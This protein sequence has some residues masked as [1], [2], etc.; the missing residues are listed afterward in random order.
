MVPLTVAVDTVAGSGATDV[1]RA[2]TRRSRETGIDAIRCLAFPAVVLIHL[3]SYHVPVETQITAPA[4]LDQLC[5]FAVPYYFVASGYFLGETERP[6]LVA[7]RRVMMRLSLVFVFWEA[8]YLVASGTSVAALSDPSLLR[9]IILRG[10]PGYHLW[11]LP[12]LGVCV[13]LAIALRRLP[14]AFRLTIGL[15]CF[16]VGIAF[17]PYRESLGLPSIGDTRTG[18]WFG[19]VFVMSGTVLRSLRI[20]HLFPLGV[21]LIAIGIASQI[22]EAAFLAMNGQGGF[23][24]HNYLLGTLPLGIGA[25]LLARA[26]PDNATVR[27]LAAV[28]RLSLGMYCVHLLFIWLLV[29]QGQLQLG[30]AEQWLRMSLVVA[31]SAVTAAGMAALPLFARVVR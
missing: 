11:Y 1:R 27:T 24:P 2:T 8:V 26:L 30:A 16:A 31:L 28:G 6:P 9:S 18:P 15:A 10:G 14:A 23:A 19:L 25:F 13:A 5:R 3:P 4:L 20:A 22:A 12:S 29:G 17:G 21:G 7:I